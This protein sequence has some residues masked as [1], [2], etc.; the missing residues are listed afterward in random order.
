M[1]K[2]VIAFL[3]ASTAA[4]AAQIDFAGSVVASCTINVTNGVL[5]LSADGLTLATTETGGVVGG[6]TVSNNTA[7]TYTLTLAEATSG[8]WDT[9]PGSAPSTTFTFPKT[10]TGQNATALNAAN[11]GSGV[12]LANVGTDTLALNMSAVGATAFPSGNYSKSILITCAP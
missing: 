5:A 11:I 3:L 2:L 6:A 7:N 8:A 10:W 4:H 12:T 9:A 1:K